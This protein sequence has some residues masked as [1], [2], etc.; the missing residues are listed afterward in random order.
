MDFVNLPISNLIAHGA[1]MILLD[2]LVD[3]GESTIIAAVT[4]NPKS[5][6]LQGGV[7]P[8][9]VGVE[10][11]AQTV[12]C[13]NGVRA[14][15]RGGNVKIGYLVSVRRLD[16]FVDDFSIGNEL[17]IQASQLYDD[18][19]MAAF[20]CLVLQADLLVAK[21]R[22][23]VYQPPVADPADLVEFD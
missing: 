6:F 15:A 10:Y 22:L 18:G 16:L 5:A 3:C 23:N 8:A 11:M 20:D 1:P 13:F 4:I 2:R 7:V 19:E 21:A 12:A 9:Y 17:R 14:L